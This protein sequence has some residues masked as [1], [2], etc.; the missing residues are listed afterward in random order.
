MVTCNLQGEE[1]NNWWKRKLYIVEIKVQSTIKKQEPFLACLVG[2]VT[3]LF[4]SCYTPR[5]IAGTLSLPLQTNP[6]D[7]IE[8][9]QDQSELQ[10]EYL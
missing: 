6:G 8:I 4:I 10:L 9:P 7:P 5:Y 2:Y 3:S 1:I